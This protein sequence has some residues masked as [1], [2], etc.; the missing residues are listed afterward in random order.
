MALNQYRKTHT[1]TYI[2]YGYFLFES[3]DRQYRQ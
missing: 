1:E 2:K 3:V